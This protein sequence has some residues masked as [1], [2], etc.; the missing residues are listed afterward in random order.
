MNRR[1]K[2]MTAI[3]ATAGLIIGSGILAAPA[4]AEIERSDRGTCRSGAIW[5]LDVERDD[6][7][8]EVDFDVDRARPG[9]TYRVTVKV[10]N[11]T[12]MTRTLRADR[13][14]DFWFNRSFRDSRGPD[15]VSVR[16]VSPRGDVCRGSVRI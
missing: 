12:V 2:K 16:A 7:R 1:T 9:D 4:S 14:G 6:G 8:L 10:N 5:D 3:G 13:D 11:R 15:T